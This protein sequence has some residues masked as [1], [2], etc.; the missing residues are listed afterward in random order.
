MEARIFCACVYL[1]RT[2]PTG[3]GFPSSDISSHLRSVSGNLEKTNICMPDSLFH[4][5]TY[6]VDI[7][8]I[9]WSGAKKLISRFDEFV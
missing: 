1:L 5:P 9:W 3:L 2:F 7:R 6:D 8:I 4:D